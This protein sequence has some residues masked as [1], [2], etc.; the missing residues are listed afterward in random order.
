MEPD[1]INGKFTLFSVGCLT[2]KMGMRP[3]HVISFCI[4]RF[5]IGD[6]FAVA[7]RDPSAASLQVQDCDLK[8]FVKETVQF[9]QYIIHDLNLPGWCPL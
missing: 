8:S 6:G 3:T 2:G 7:I 4:G 1:E 9:F 5:E